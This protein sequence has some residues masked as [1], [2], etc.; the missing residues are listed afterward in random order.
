MSTLG[1][2]GRIMFRFSNRTTRIRMAAAQAKAAKAP[3][4]FFSC[5]ITKDTPLNLVGGLLTEQAGGLEDQNDDEQSEGKGVHE[6][7]GA[8]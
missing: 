2:L 4:R 8:L 6:G 1:T 3:L 5:L 7:G